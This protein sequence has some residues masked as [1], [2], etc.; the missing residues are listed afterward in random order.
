M[1]TS[2]IAFLASHVKACMLPV[3]SCLSQCPGAATK[4]EQAVLGPGW[5]FFRARLSTSGAVHI[6]IN[7][8]H[9]P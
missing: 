7:H 5:V 8:L 9:G 1:N 3:H 2:H 6:Q 4:Y